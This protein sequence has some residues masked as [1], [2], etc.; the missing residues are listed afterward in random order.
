MQFAIVGAGALGSVYGARLA[1]AGQV[2]FVV[3]DLDRAPRLIHIDRVNGGAP[4]GDSLDAPACSLSIPEGT[5]TVLVT[6]RVDQ[7]DDALLDKIAR[8]SKSDA[9]VVILAPLL[10]HSYERAKSKLGDRLV[11]AMPGVIAYEPDPDVPRERRVRYW[12]PRSSPTLLE[13]RGPRVHALVE[14]MRRVG[15]PADASTQV[16]ST[17]PATTMAF[18]PILTGIAAAGGSIDRMMND[19]AIMKLGFAAAKETRALAK[20]VGELPSWAS[21]FFKFASPF[22][23]RAGMRLGQSRAP[24]AFV[25]LEKHF[26]TKLAA[27]N[28]AIF[29]EIEQLANERGI[30]ID[31]LRKLVA[32]A[33]GG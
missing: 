22:T 6:V 14:T 7:L 30:A 10:P 15:L 4:H 23:A 18:F 25:F 32:R 27:Q 16:A 31:N 20:T 12:T 5:D 1:H 17:N 8:E 13:D 26:G 33:H 19:D 24:E 28:M 29:R 9:L 2:V 21:L 3:R 11:A